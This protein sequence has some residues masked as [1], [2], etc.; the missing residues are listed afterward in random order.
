MSESIFQPSTLSESIATARKAQQFVGFKLQG[1]EYAFPIEQIREIVIPSQLTSLPQVPD[2]IQGVCNLRGVIIP[3]VNL[4]RLFAMPASAIDTDSRTIVV[5]VGTRTMGCLVD[6]VTQVHRFTSDTIQPAPEIVQ[7]GR[8]AYITGF[9]KV[10]GAPLI[11]LNI[12]ELLEPAKLD[13]VH[14]SAV[15]QFGQPHLLPADRP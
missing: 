9:A 10:D 2:Y 14:A 8:T 15:Q 12:E 6:S 3:I 7:S 13:K 5:N 11:L 4:R 1:Q